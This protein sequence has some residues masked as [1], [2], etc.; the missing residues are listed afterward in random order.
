MSVTEE[1]VGAYAGKKRVAVYVDPTIHKTLKAMSLQR[2]QPIVH[3]VEAWLSEKA[4]AW[5]LEQTQ[6]RKE[7]P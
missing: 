1:K 6:M 2:D 3:M 4:Q 7:R 5:R